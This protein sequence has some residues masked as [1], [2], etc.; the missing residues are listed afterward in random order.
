MSTTGT[1]ARI[2]AYLGETAARL[3][4][5]RR[6]R[7][8]ILTELRDGLEQAV[9]DQIMA[10]LPAGDAVSAAIA[11]FGTPARVA[12]AFAAEL[13]IAYA[14]QT[15]GWFVATG[16]LVGIWWLLLLRPAPWRGGLTTLVAAIPVIPLI[17]AGLAAA[18]RRSLPPAG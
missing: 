18:G 8:R 14:R 11:G 17:A 2:D 5:P 1:A 16:P 12:D 13:T 7:A 3:H 15:L 9:E 6:R 4:G 10:G